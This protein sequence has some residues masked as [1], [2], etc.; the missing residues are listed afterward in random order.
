M[1]NMRSTRKYLA[2]A[3]AAA[4]ALALA[5]CSS[6][7]SSGSSN[8]A[9]GKVTL[10]FWSNANANPLLGVFQTLMKSYHASHPNV[11]FTYVPI[12]NEAYDTKIQVAL[13]GNNPPD[14]FFQRGGGFMATQAKSGKLANLKTY[15]SSWIGELGPLAAAWQVN[16]AQYG[17][18]YDQHTVGFWYRKDVFAHA[19]ITA[20][21]ATMPELETDITKLKAA[22]IA[23]IAVGSKD[24]WP[25]AFYWD[26]LAVRECSIATL[27]TAVKA[28]SAN[29]P[30]FLKAGTDLQAFMASKPFQPAFLNTPAQVGAGSSAGMVAAGKAA[31]ELQGDWDPS[32]MTA[33]V[34]SKKF[35][36]DIG[37]FPFPSVPGAPGNSQVL[38]G[39]GDGNS[40]S[41]TAPEPACA[42]FLSYLES[43][44]SQKLLVSTANVGLPANPAAASALTLP[45]EQQILQLGKQSPYIQEYFDLA[46]PTNV[47]TALDAAVANMF[48]SKGSPQSIV[49]AIDQ[50]AAQQ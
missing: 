11:S 21:P 39:G 32:V 48:A 18:P 28:V 47:G 34:P 50:A 26:Y 37:W 7:G 8:S 16:G 42:N 44:S 10:T 46:Y 45:A 17:V 36:S 23:P 29:Y 40:C 33:L 12:Q 43:T 49:T 27:K 1:T 35:L 14:V 38:L 30:C 2:V 9:N 22:N 31:M 19:G 41:S 25:D 4:A 13:Q 24:Q 15:D 6:S 5:A 20:P 3:V